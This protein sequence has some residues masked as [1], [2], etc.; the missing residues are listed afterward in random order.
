MKPKELV[1][2]VITIIMVIILGIGFYRD[3][4]KKVIK[5]TIGLEMTDDY[6]IEKMEKRGFLLYRTSYSARIRLNSANP[7]VMVEALVSKYNAN[8]EF[9]YYTDFVD[10]KNE[11]LDKETIVPNPDY[12]SVIFVMGVEDEDGHEVVYMVDVEGENLTYLY[13]YYSR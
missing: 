2:I 7:D 12:N 6:K 13:V 9:I 10:F 11:V 8:G 5:R 3:D 1:L 4:N